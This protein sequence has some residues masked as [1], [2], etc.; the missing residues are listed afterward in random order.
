M[1]WLKLGCKSFFRKYEKQQYSCAVNFMFCT[2]YNTVQIKI[3]YNVASCLFNEK[4]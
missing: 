2:P 1:F 3:I 4:K